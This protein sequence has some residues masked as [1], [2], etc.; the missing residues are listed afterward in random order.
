MGGFGE[1]EFV[2]QTEHAVYLGCGRIVADLSCGEFTA[3][4]LLLRFPTWD[5]IIRPKNYVELHPKLNVYWKSLH[6]VL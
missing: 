4:Q 5:E 3:A 6:H 1:S 2:L